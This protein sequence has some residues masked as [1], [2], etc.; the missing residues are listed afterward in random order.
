MTNLDTNLTLDD[1]RI[2]ETALHN[3]EATCVRELSDPY[4]P[5]RKQWNDDLRAT[6]ATLTKVRDVLSAAE[7]AA[8]DAAVSDLKL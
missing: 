5:L 6:R 2:V 7:T 8:V 4:H 3:H 1:L